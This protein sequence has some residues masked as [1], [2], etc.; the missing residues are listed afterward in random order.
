MSDQ[1]F[2]GT[3]DGGCDGFHPGNVR[4]DRTTGLAVRIHPEVPRRELDGLLSK[5]CGQNS[6]LGNGVP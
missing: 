6:A 2:E 4:R 5:D 1:G 3:E